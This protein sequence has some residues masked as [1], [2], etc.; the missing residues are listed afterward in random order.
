M[1]HPT[2]QEAFQ[3]CPRNQEE[4]DQF[5][6]GE[7]FLSRMGEGFTETAFVYED[8]IWYGNERDGQGTHYCEGTI[9]N[10]LPIF[11]NPETEFIQSKLTEKMNEVMGKKNEGYLVTDGMGIFDFQT[12]TRAVWRS[13]LAEQGNRTVAWF[14]LGEYLAWMSMEPN[15]WEYVKA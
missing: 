12:R 8:K 5:F 2:L 9:K 14:D 6:N 11:L 3:S 10:V 15:E 7:W 13:A 1:E 4:W